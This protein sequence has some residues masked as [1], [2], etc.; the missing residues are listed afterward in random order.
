MIYDAITEEVTRTLNTNEHIP[1][2]FDNIFKQ[3][4][5]NSDNVSQVINNRVRSAAN[6]FEAIREEPNP[7]QKQR[8]KKHRKQSYEKK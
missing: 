7:S 6:S 8:L 1:G 3:Y 2:R 4:I 5:N